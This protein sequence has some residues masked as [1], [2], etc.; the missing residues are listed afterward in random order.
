MIFSQ[1]LTFSDGAKFADLARNLVEGKGYGTSFSFFGGGVSENLNVGV[2]P[3]PGVSPA[4]PYAISVFFRIFGVNDF[5]VIATSFFFYLLAVIFTFLLSRKLFGKLVGV[6]AALAVAFSVNFIE[7][8]MIGASEPL[9]IFLI[10]SSFYLIILKRRS[11]TVAGFL[12]L[13]ISYFTRPLAFV[14]IAGGLLLYLLVRYSAK[15]ALYI[16]LIF[17]IAGFLADKFLLSRLHG[18]YFL[19]TI[20]GRGVNAA[21]SYLPGQASSDILRGGVVQTTDNLAVFKKAFYNLY[22]FYRLLPQI[23]SPYLAALF[24]L[25]TF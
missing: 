8:A 18:Q 21:V 9:F 2:F 7:Y 1:Y 3:A 11:A 5:A 16:F 17:L 23:M 24:C 15:K 14:F 4:M 22:N 13:A 19:Y 25:G 20:T 6:L 10:V 12:F